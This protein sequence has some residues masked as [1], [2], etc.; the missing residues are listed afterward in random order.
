MR[1]VAVWL[2]FTALFLA[3]PR[4]RAATPPE[5]RFEAPP[6]MAPLV[7]RLQ[8]VDRGRL[9]RVMAVVGLDQAGL[10]IRV[11][12][13]PEGT[14]P[15]RR[16]P[17]WS[18]GYAFG[19]AGLVV[20]L[21]SRVP[22]YPDRSLESVL[23]HEVA[24]V[25][26]ARAAGRRPVPRWFDEGVAMAVSRVTLSD[27]THL[28]FATIRRGSLSL[29]DLDRAFPAGPGAAGR[30]YALAGAFVRHLLDTY[31]QGVVADIL[32]EIA[33][34]ATFDTA[35][36]RRAGAPL[37]EVEAHFWRQL[38]IWQKWVPFLGSS[39][40]LWILISLLALV[41]FRRRAQRD[42][43]QR[44]RWEAEEAWAEAGGPSDEW[45]N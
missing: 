15:A 25:L 18:V 1:R 27:R 12:L 17:S 35:F 34:G 43:E 6:A 24:H 13:A 23:L 10:P 2:A 32:S 4:A 14:P 37:G 38:D 44:A 26:V 19:A 40:F 16:A 36:A 39:T 29:A 33:A 42:A 11:V 3:V 22:G 20:L 21:P 41:A 30:A 5:L 7:E 28:V 45:V 31:G 8:G 9:L